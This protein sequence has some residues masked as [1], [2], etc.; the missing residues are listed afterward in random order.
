[1]RTITFWVEIQVRNIGDRHT[2]VYDMNLAFEDNGNKHSFKKAYF[3]DVPSQE[4]RVL[5]PAHDVINIWAD[6]YERYEGSDKEQIKCTLAIC[7]THR[8]EVV[9]TVSQRVK[10]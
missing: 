8:T 10:T 3:R 2:S 1:M 5:V 6:F 9:E 7:H 4:Q